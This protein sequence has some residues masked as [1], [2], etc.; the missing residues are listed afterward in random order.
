MAAL[1]SGAHEIHIAFE[2]KKLKKSAHRDQEAAAAHVRELLSPH[3][4]LVVFFG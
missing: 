2:I 1:E 4:L 3:A